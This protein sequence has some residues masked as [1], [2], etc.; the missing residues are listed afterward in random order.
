MISL[1]A[2]P[3][4]EG[5]VWY[6]PVDFVGRALAPVVR[7]APRA[8]QAVEADSARRRPDAARRRTD[9]TDRHA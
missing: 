3:V 6:V 2:A 8:A 9:R 4:H 7:D 5:R 1:P